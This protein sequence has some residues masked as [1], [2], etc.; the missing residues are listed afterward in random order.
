MTMFVRHQ[1]FVVGDVHTD[2]SVVA[3]KSLGSQDMTDNANLPR[4]NASTRAFGAGIQGFAG[5]LPMR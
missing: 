1:E 3:Q 5:A 4:F 2:T